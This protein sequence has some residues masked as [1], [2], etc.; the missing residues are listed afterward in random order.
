MQ[1]DEC[2]TSSNRLDTEDKLRKLSTLE[3]AQNTRNSVVLDRAY[4]VLIADKIKVFD[5]VPESSDESS[6]EHLFVVDR[7]EGVINLNPAKLQFS[8]KLQDS[9]VR[10]KHV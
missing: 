10:S 1:Q 5:H 9:K 8:L 4:V 6:P 7:K 2:E 3:Q